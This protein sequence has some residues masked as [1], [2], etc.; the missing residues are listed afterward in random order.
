MKNNSVAAVLA[1]VL[2]Y[3]L[4]AF[5]WG[6]TIVENFDYGSSVIAPISSGIAG[7]GWA[8]AWSGGGAQ[9][10]AYLFRTAITNSS[11]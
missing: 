1:I 6:S 11:M 7:D 3:G 2:T 4:G 9:N 10:A 5:A 8:G